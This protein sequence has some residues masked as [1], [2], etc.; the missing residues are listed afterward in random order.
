MAFMPS[1]QQE[2]FFKWIV[3]ETGSVVLE[4]VAGSGK[5]TTVVEGLKLME[6]TIALIAYNKKI[7]EEI[8]TKAPVKAGLTIGT[9]H[10]IGFSIWRKVASKVVVDANKCRNIYKNM[11]T[12]KEDYEL[13]S[14]VLSLVSLAKQADSVFINIS[15]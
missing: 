9:V 15:S 8:K 3:E 12:E 7:A 5:T 1:I 4:A 13:Q 11:Y 10:S 14:P 6:G 2:N